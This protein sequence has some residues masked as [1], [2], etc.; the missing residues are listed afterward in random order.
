MRL[1]LILLV[2][3]TSSLILVAFLVEH[4]LL[5]N[6]RWNVIT[7][8]LEFHLILNGALVVVLQFAEP[9]VPAKSLQG[10]PRVMEVG[11]ALPFDIVLEV[12]SGGVLGPL[13]TILDSVADDLF[14]VHRILSKV[15]TSPIVRCELR[16]VFLLGF[17]LLVG[18]CRYLGSSA[19]R[20]P[21][22]RERQ[23]RL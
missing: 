16:L 20:P 19:A 17:A 18:A 23:R 9:T 13:A 14:D 8:K 5:S 4:I 3:A 7:P 2:T 1:R 21:F 10:I 12:V 11:F 6:F 15:L 22:F